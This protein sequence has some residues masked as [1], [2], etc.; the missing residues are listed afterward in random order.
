MTQA[1]YSKK[2]LGDVAEYLM[3]FQNAL[4][5]E[6]MEGYE[7]LK[8]AIITNGIPNL[9]NRTYDA[10][11]SIISANSEGKYVSN[12]DSWSSVAFKCERHDGVMDISFNLSKDH[13]RAKKYPTAYKFEPAIVELL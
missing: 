5:T 9:A 10:S 1:I 3:S 13:P 7:S 2:E 11:S 12:V 4:T 6:F 8:Q